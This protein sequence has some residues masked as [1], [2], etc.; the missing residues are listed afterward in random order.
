MTMDAAIAE[1]RRSM[2][3][4]VLTPADSGFAQ[5][6]AEA[7]WNADIRRQPAAIV[8]PTSAEDVAAR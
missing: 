3:G 6:R 7:I 8:R 2:A 1:L 5:A 4:E